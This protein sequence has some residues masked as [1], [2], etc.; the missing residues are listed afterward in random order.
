MKIKSIYC[1]YIC[2]SIILA[3]LSNAEIIGQNPFKNKVKNKFFLFN[4]SLIYFKDTTFHYNYFYFVKNQSYGV[5][6]YISPDTIMLSAYYNT[7]KRIPIHVKEQKNNTDSIELILINKN[8]FTYKYD[9]QIH[10]FDEKYFLF[11]VSL[12]L[13]DTTSIKIHK[14][15]IKSFT[16][17]FPFFDRIEKKTD[18]Y[19]ILDTF[20]NKFTIIL[21]LPYNYS[22]LYHF[23][24]EKYVIKGDTIYNIKYMMCPFVRVKKKEAAIFLKKNHPL[25]DIIY[26]Y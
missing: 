5:Y 19:T 26:F 21:D 13:K 3:F 25:I 12:V 16:I 18:N 23:N 11:D 14:K 2:I 8:K 24:D 22:H 6:R 17:E 10:F 9:A 1:K 20:S 7:N 4:R 15:D